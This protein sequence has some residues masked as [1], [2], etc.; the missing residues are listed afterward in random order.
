MA[1]G[2]KKAGGERQRQKA[3]LRAIALELP[4]RDGLIPGTYRMVDPSRQTGIVDRPRLPTRWTARHVGMRLIEAH[5]IVARMPGN[6]WPKQYGTAWPVF[7]QEMALADRDATFVRERN[8]RINIGAGADEIA[9][10]GE[11]LC[12]PL[13]FLSATPDVARD[14][15]LWA[16]QI[17]EEEF[18][19]IDDGDLAVPWEGLQMIADCLN[20][21]N[22]VVR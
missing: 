1:R 22:E 6:I 4:P 9:R 3:E 18:E 12:W 13:Q 16:S 15:N 14:V 19:N 20:A 8:S 2:G 17:T 21:A 5:R 11:A 10:T 7:R